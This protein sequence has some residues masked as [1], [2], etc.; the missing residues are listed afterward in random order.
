MHF[1]GVEF[2]MWYRE[3]SIINGKSCEISSEEMR[4]HD[5]T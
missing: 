3:V 1:V 5:E 2:V 4:S